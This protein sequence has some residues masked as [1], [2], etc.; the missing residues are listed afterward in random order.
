MI[1]FSIALALV[2]AT[3]LAHA[4]GS[5]Y[6][7]GPDGRTYSQTPCADGTLLD[8]ADPRTA[9]QR[10]EAKRVQ[11][12]ERKAAADLE[13]ERKAAEKAAPGAASL[14][15]EPAASA[16]AKEPARRKAKAAGTKDFVAAVPGAKTASAAGK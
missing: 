14:G 6:R 3:G 12:A 8:A 4:A 13:R 2:A 5:I 16:P 9:A 15:A 10:A 1:R 7:C 11:A